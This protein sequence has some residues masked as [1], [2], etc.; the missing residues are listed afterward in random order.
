METKDFKERVPHQIK[1]A[2]RWIHRRIRTALEYHAVQS[3]LVRNRELLSRPRTSDR[4]FII[5]NGPS[6]KNQ[7]LSLLRGETTIVMNSFFL[8]PDYE[9]LQPTYHVAV[10][11]A[12]VTDTTS[13]LGWLRDLEGRS[14]KTALLFS[15]DGAPLFKKHGIFLNRDVYYVL[16]SEQ[17]CDSGKILCDLTRPVPGIA[18]VTLSCIL[19]ALYLGC[20][21]IYLL[22]CD[23][24]WL[25]TPTTV[26]HFYEDN[27]HYSASIAMYPYETLLESTL[28]LWRGYRRVREFAVHRGMKIYNATKGGFLDVFP[29]VEYE[30]L[31]SGRPGAAVPEARP[32]S[33]SVGS[34]PGPAGAGGR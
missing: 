27:P 26:N 10:D 16:H 15:V 31:F 22:G 5:A 3:L 25:G 24:D 20:R 33:V 14:K 9:R 1:P 6:I 23:H 4:C 21:E 30:S 13:N 2:L 29:R 8:H 11:P 17:G 18:C 12:T 34:G 28:S 7:D 32:V 19:L